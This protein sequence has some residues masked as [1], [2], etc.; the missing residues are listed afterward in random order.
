MDIKEIVKKYDGVDIYRVG[1]KHIILQ[2]S[3]KTCD[4]IYKICSSM[5]NQRIHVFEVYPE[6]VSNRINWVISL[7]RLNKRNKIIFHFYKS[8]R[9][10]A[11]H[12]ALSCSKIGSNEGFNYVIDSDKVVFESIKN[13]AQSKGIPRQKYHLEV[14]Y[15]FDE[16]HNHL[17][18]DIVTTICKLEIPYKVHYYLGEQ[19]FD[20]IMKSRYPDEFKNEIIKNFKKYTPDGI[21]KGFKDDN[22]IWDY[23]NEMIEDEKEI[24]EKKKKKE[25]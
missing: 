3:N 16:Y 15:R 11:K 24:R 20:T 6:A 12:I 8:I 23:I 7:G 22:D 19:T 10:Y 13:I 4:Y 25:E 9:D 1:N 17:Y 21:L 18:L 2:L 14:V 5:D